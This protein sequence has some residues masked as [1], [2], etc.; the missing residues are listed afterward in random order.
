MPIEGAYCEVVVFCTV[1]VCDCGIAG[2]TVSVVT[3][4][5]VVVA[6]SLP[7]A[8]SA[9]IDSDIASIAVRP[10]TRCT[11]FFS[12]TILKPFM[13]V[14]FERSNL[15]SAEMFHRRRP[16]EATAKELNDDVEQ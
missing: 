4:R 16:V 15:A 5:V 13:I 7:Q 8:V 10:A 3:V 14:Y 6:G 11:E 2:A 1:V 9:P 12:V